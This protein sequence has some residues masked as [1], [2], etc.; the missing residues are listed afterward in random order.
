MYLSFSWVLF[1]HLA[2][3]S[4]AEEQARAH[5]VEIERRASPESSALPSCSLCPLASHV[6]SC[7]KAEGWVR[8]PW[9]RDDEQ[10]CGKADLI[11]DRFSYSRRCQDPTI[12][13]PQRSQSHRH[14]SLDVASY[15]E[16]PIKESDAVALQ[17]TFR[18]N[19]HVLAYWHT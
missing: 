19:R 6:G 14:D 1:L 12:K 16:Y 5:E 17:V 18:Q 15:D 11:R 8:Q 9:K 13:L 4:S 2:L 7:R 3:S 10:N